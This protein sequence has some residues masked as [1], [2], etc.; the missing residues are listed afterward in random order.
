MEIIKSK[1]KVRDLSLLEIKA[2]KNAILK[3]PDNFPKAVIR[4]CNQRL[5]HAG[6]DGFSKDLLKG[7]PNPL[8]ADPQPSPVTEVPSPRSTDQSS[9][10]STVVTA[11][12]VTVSITKE[13]PTVN[14]ESTPANAAQ[15]SGSDRSVSFLA[16][17]EDQQLIE[18]HTVQ[19]KDIDSEF[20]N[21]E[22]FS[23][24]NGIDYYGSRY[25]ALQKASKLNRAFKAGEIVFAKCVDC[26]HYFM[27]G[28][29]D[30][31]FYKEKGWQIPNHCTSCRAAKK[32]RARAS[33]RINT[34]SPVFT[35]AYDE[36]SQLVAAAETTKQELENPPMEKKFIFT[37]RS[38][39]GEEFSV[40]DSLEKAHAAASFI[41]NMIYIK[42]CRIDLCKKCGRYFYNYDGS[43]CPKKRDFCGSCTQSLIVK[44]KEPTV[45][46]E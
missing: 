19:R 43:I 40:Y 14:H 17:N 28:T 5:I 33:K 21:K 35:L 4:A 29:K 3:T 8:S 46:P 38:K 36:S 20:A 10:H 37:S 30:T 13:A 16:F 6:E 23:D 25:V 34:A 32:A 1:E 42:E 15:R 26:G 22:V 7:H 27:V 11:A 18:V 31:A 2:L 45:Q 12:P 24:N 44:T 39:R 9:D 41:N